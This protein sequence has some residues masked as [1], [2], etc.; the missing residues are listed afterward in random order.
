MVGRGCYGRPWFLHQVAHFLRT[1]Q[2]LD[3]PGLTQRKAIL[4]EHY[5]AMLTYFGADA[6]MRL[7][8][9]HLGWYTRGLPR[10]AEFRA[11]VMQLN[12][13]AAVEN[14]VHVFFDR[15]MEQGDR[16]NVEQ[17]ADL[18]AAAA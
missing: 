4:L 3:P 18:E 8:R 14:L 5:R 9:K 12:E 10:S 1:G 6:G 15:L 13:T 17:G 11:S 2:R 16:I 7:A